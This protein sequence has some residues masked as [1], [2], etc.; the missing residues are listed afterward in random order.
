MHCPECRHPDTRVIDTRVRD[1]SVRRR[2]ECNVCS[3]RF[4]TQERVFNTK[5]M[6]QKR[7]RTL[8]EFSARKLTRSIE[9]ACAKRVLPVGAIDNI[10]D[11]VYH[12]AISEG[13]ERIESGVIGEM[14][15]DGLKSL[16]HVA[17]MRFASV[18]KDFDDLERFTTEA[19]SLE[20]MD[21]LEADIQGALLPSAAS[22]NLSEI[23]RRN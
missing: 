7:D 2:R 5:L 20:A 17:Y 4:T 9:I 12:K 15:L 6:V 19:S 13:R 10:V 18:Y 8:E 23:A 22:P 11:S 3:F 1:E 21:Q 14:V 16:D